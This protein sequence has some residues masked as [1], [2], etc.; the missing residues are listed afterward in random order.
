MTRP[1]HTAPVM[2]RVTGEITE[3]QGYPPD[4]LEHMK[5]HIEILKELGVEPIDD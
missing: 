2:L 5:N 3:W 4:V 1:N